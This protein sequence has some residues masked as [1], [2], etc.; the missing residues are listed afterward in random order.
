MRVRDHFRAHGRKSVSLPTTLRDDRA[1]IEE[2]ACIKNLGLGGAYVELD[3][4][5]E[6]EPT[7]LRLD[8]AVV[9]EVTAPSLW[10]PLILRGR[11]AWLRRGSGDK[12]ARFGVRFEHQEEGTLFALFQLLGTQV[13]E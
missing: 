8:A 5:A 12:P 7:L 11:I 2:Q 9:L 13:F 3:P 10:D 1:S 4:G 6:S